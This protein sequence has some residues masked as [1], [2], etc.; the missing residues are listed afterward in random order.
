MVWFSCYH[1]LLICVSIC[2]LGF[3]NYSKYCLC[4]KWLVLISFYYSLLN[5]EYTWPW[6]HIALANCPPYLCIHWILLQVLYDHLDL[7]IVVWFSL[8]IS[9]VQLTKSRIFPLKVARNHF[10]TNCDEPSIFFAVSFDGQSLERPAWLQNC[11]SS[12]LSFGMPLTIMVTA[13]SYPEPE[14]VCRY[15]YFQL[16][17]CFSYLWIKMVLVVHNNLHG[18]VANG[19]YRLSFTSS[20]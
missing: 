19:T 11:S 2:Q 13:R 16:H 14:S 4:T 9:I 3:P 18:V 15:Y 5:R 7:Y 17:I 12:T 8:A 1:G 6:G 20:G 10:K